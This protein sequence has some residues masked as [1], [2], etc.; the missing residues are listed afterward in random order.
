MPGN[1]SSIEKTDQQEIL[2]TS[3]CKVEKA[4]QTEKENNNCGNEPT[5]HKELAKHGVVEETEQSE[6]EKHKEKTGQSVISDHEQK[7]TENDKCDKENKREENAMHVGKEEG[8]VLTEIK[9]KDEYERDRIRETALDINETSKKTKTDQHQYEEQRNDTTEVDDDQ[10]KLV[11]RESEEMTG[12]PQLQKLECMEEIRKSD[13]CNVEEQNSEAAICGNLSSNQANIPESEEKTSQLKTMTIITVLE[14]THN[15]MDKLECESSNDNN[16]M[17][18]DE[19]HLIDV[20]SVNNAKHLDILTYKNIKPSAEFSENTEAK[21]ANFCKLE[22][23]KLTISNDT[24][25]DAN[26][27]NYVTDNL[28]SENT[29]HSIDAEDDH[30]VENGWEDYWKYYGYSLVWES[31]HARHGNLLE[32]SAKADKVK[33]PSGLSESDTEESI[34]CEE[35]ASKSD[36]DDNKETSNYSNSEEEGTSLQNHSKLDCSGYNVTHFDNEKHVKHQTKLHCMHDNVPNVANEAELTIDKCTEINL[37]ASG[38]S[39]KQQFPVEM[40]ESE[41]TE[42]ETTEN[43]EEIQLPVIASTDIQILWNQNYEEVYAYYFEQY[44]FWKSEGYAFD[45]PPSSKVD[46]DKTKEAAGQLVKNEQTDA[47]MCG[48]RSKRSKKRQQSKK[49]QTQHHSSSQ[50]SLSSFKQ[51]QKSCQGNDEEDDGDSPDDKVPRNLKRA[52][53]LDVEE[54]RNP[55]L[56]KAYKLMGFKVAH[57]HGRNFDDLPKFGSAKVQFQCQK[58]QAKNKKLSIFPRQLDEQQEEL[59]QQVKDF[60]QSKENTDVDSQSSEMEEPGEVDSKLPKDN[61][62]ELQSLC[63][64]SETKTVNVVTSEDFSI[65]QLDMESQKQ[66][67]DIAKYWYQRYRLFSQF[68]KGIKMDKEG[69]FS[70]TP[71]RI[72]QHIAERCRCDLIVDAF[73]GVG[74]NAIQFAFTCE[75]VIAIDI[76]PVKIACARHNAEIYGVHDRIEFI[77]GDF[78]HLAPI[79]KADVVFLSPPWGGPDY[80]KAEVFDI[81]TMILLDGYKLF[82][83]AKQVTNNIAY[84]MPRNVDAEQLA[85]LA[86]RGGKVEIEQNFVNKKCKTVTA[87]YGHLISES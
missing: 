13:I 33:V 36:I 30:S 18:S 60:L 72:A 81:K 9:N 49:Q 51:Q 41:L 82:E 28:V 21:T 40:F 4:E 32:T 10:A 7:E 50:V 64:Q 15:N 43:S 80:S 76:D 86:G 31:W 61:P 26:K 66:D 20:S 17:K 85:S 71:E 3:D 34:S 45:V 84:F 25:K 83:K 58:L 39:E 37:S 79:L 70:V 87:Y 8:T 62:T 19:K 74:G 24:K 57:P 44:K 14:K 11:F 73:C 23:S 35:K 42:Y 1:W 78:M 27:V 59:L 55:Q 68:D 47:V 54:Q 52:H 63:Y 5:V 12:Q 38:L 53:E 56:V 48:S 29:S 46:D 2:V 69:W 6:T 16:A 22:L 75:R 67:P 65:E 77:V